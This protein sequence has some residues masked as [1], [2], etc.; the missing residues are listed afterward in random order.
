MAWESPFNISFRTPTLLTNDPSSP[1]Q[2]MTTLAPLAPLLSPPTGS[3]KL[4]SRV[5]GEHGATRK[6]QA[7]LVVSDDPAYT[8]ARGAAFWLRTRMDWSYC[9]VFDDETVCGLDEAM[10]RSGHAEL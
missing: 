10:A 2:S 5:R 7:E 6:H 4:P 8:T 1:R 9:A 3:R